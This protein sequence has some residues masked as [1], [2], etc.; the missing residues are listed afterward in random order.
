[1]ILYSLTYYVQTKRNVLNF[2]FLLSANRLSN[3]YIRVGDSFDDATFDPTTYAVCWYQS[4]P[5]GRGETRQFICNQ[6]IVGRYVTIHFPSN[7]SEFLTMCE[8]Q[9]FSDTGKNLVCFVL[10]KIKTT[11]ADLGNARDAPP[12]PNS[13]NFMQ[14]LGKFGKI[15]C[16]RPLEGWRP[17][18][19]EILDSP[20]D[21]VY[22]INARD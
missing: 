7:K 21:Q 8:V 1:M 2:P 16:W 3:F 17:N 22:I 12:G 10:P 19:G 18:L 4:D 15:V 5:I 13:F 14:F 6:P 11:V 9:V 20:L